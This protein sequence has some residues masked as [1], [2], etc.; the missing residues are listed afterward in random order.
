VAATRKIAH[1]PAARR[2]KRAPLPKVWN[3]KLYV[4]GRTPKSVR[5]L[6]N[7]TTICEQHLEGRY[8]IEVIDLLEHPH[9]ARGAQI[10]A[11]PALV[12]DLPEPVR[13]IIGDLSDT[14]RVLVG[15]ALQPQVD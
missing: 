7:L 12:I 14:E 10:V 2:R 11:M 8:H 15:L 5:A 13:Q 6:A 1:K 9:L 3:L 4:A